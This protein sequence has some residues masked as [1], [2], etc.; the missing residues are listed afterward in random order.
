LRDKSAEPLGTEK[1]FDNLSKEVSIV[2]TDIE[3]LQNLFVDFDSWSDAEKLEL[4]PSN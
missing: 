2:E 4:L 3:R 1:A